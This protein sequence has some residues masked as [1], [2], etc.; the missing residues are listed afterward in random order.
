MMMCD[1]LL[2]ICILKTVVIIVKYNIL[3]IIHLCCSVNLFKLYENAIL[4][5]L[6]SASAYMIRG[7]KTC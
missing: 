7:L 1:M 5:V 2:T 3:V 4:L 6:V